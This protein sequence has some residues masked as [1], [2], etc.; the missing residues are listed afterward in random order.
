MKRKVALAKTG[1]ITTKTFVSVSS[2][3]MEGKEQNLCQKLSSRVHIKVAFRGS[4]VYVT[5][6]FLPCLY[7]VTVPFRMA[8]EGLCRK[9]Q[10]R[11]VTWVI[12]LHGKMRTRCI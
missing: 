8:A 10:R 2:G 12:M 5:F 9:D 3:F 4:W 11:H 7:C 1:L 6:N